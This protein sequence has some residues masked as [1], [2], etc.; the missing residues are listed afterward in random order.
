MAAID[1]NHN[2]SKWHQLVFKLEGLNILRF[3]VVN[4]LS[5]ITQLLEEKRVLIPEASCSYVIWMNYDWLS[6]QSFNR[7]PI[8]T[9]LHNIFNLDDV[10]E[11]FQLYKLEVI[12]K[13]NENDSTCRSKWWNK[14]VRLIRLVYDDCFKIKSEINLPHLIIVNI[15]IPVILALIELMANYFC[16]LRGCNHVSFNISKHINRWVS[17]FHKMYFTMKKWNQANSKSSPKMH[18]FKGLKYPRKQNLN[19]EKI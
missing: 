11:R 19:L 10:E 16:D 6:P 18:I 12:Y 17:I 8:F 9:V 14:W 7:C 5:E 15:S 1:S 4:V 3:N 2:P 13:G